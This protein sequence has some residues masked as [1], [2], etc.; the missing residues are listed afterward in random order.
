[1]QLSKFLLFGAL[2]TT[3]TTALPQRG[4]NRGGD[5]QGGRPRI[6]PPPNSDLNNPPPP[7][8]P[9]P[10][11][12]PPPADGAPAAG[13][14]GNGG[15]G[16]GGGGNAG[17]INTAVIPDD[18]GIQTGSGVGTNGTP[19]PA[20]CPPA[21]TDPKF[22]GGLSQLLTDGFFPDPSVPAPINLARFND[23]GDQSVQTNRDR[24]T[25]MV[26]VLQSLSGTKGVGCP[27]ASVPVLIA[28]QRTGVV[29]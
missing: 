17:Q 18:F 19:I 24:A 12:A 15:G 29:V 4:G 3:A 6:R 25:A 20:D 27:G 8:P 21:P 1:M 10:P 7:P 2:F 28:Q 23:A 13:G 11:A 16:G 5:G 26:Q 14:G 22:L 9:A